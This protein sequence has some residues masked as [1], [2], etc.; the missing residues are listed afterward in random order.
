MTISAMCAQCSARV[1]R[2]SRGHVVWVIGSSASDADVFFFSNVT[3]PYVGVGLV[4]KCFRIGWTRVHTHTRD[5]PRAHTPTNMHIYIY[6]YIYILSYNWNY[7]AMIDGRY[8]CLMMMFHSLHCCS[9]HTRIRL[10]SFTL[11]RVPW[12]HVLFLLTYLLTYLLEFRCRIHF[13]FAFNY[14]SEMLALAFL[15]ATYVCTRGVPTQGY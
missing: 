4:R 14:S 8:A 10:Y 12:M 1:G 3:T 13:L 11:H 9:C 15:A 5:R 6:I 2:G 7:K